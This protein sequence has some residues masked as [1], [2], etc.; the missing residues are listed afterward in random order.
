MMKRPDRRYHC[1]CQAVW[2]LRLSPDYG[3][4]AR[5]RLGG[6]LQAY[7][8]DLAAGGAEGSL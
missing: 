6:Q 7:R 5:G 4:A 2:P 8:A 3:V 1:T